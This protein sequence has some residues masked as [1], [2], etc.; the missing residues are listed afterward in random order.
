MSG[1]I[2]ITNGMFIAMIVNLMF[3]KAIG[4]TQGVLARIVGQ[5]MWIAT[6][7]GTLQGAVMMFVTY[8]VIRKKPHCD[9]IA[10][11]E[12]LLGKWFAKIVALVIFLFFLTGFGPIM[13]TLV[14]HLRDYFLPEAPLVLFIV[15]P[16]LVGAL[17]CFY[18]LEVMARV[19][20]VGL[21]FIFL[22]NALITVGSTN[23]FD[24]RNLL[25]VLENGFPHTAFASIH[26]DAD[27][28]YSIMLATLVMPFVKDNK[29]RGG[30][31]GVTGI[32]VSG[33]LI[34]IWA[35]LEGAVLSAEVTSQYA[36]S[37][38][39]LARNA[40]IGNFM[41]RY[42]MVMIA[43]YSLSMLFEVMFSIYGASVSISK[44]FGLKSNRVMIVPVSV[45][46]GLFS[47]WVIE[48][49]FRAMHFVE[50]DWPRIALPIA[51]GLPLILLGLRF[52]FGRKL[53]SV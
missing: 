40:H 14:Y 44:C 47:Y 33:M 48:D 30:Q 11:S 10:I 24:I 49:H 36:V 21:L 25:P 52:M 19:A 53:E 51:F 22:L 7:L 15:A 6:L 3:N 45:L 27:W 4:V 29:T 12:M 23:E 50:H 8:L 13:F 9:F 43:L 2:Q 5:D 18:G 34:V 16:L 26:F 17:G 32:L 42:E 35:I 37:C 1:K 38:M 20:L 46:L 39:K 28:A 41:Q 31:L